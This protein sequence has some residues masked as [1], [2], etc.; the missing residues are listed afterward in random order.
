MKLIVKHFNE[1]ELSELY[2]ILKARQEVFVVEQN[3]AYVDADG[4][5]KD[6][7][8]VFYEENGKILACLRVL[9]RGVSFPEVSF[10]R[11]ITTKR[12]CG[13]G[14]KIIEAGVSVAKE[15]YR[16]DCIKISAQL[17]AKGFY[18]KQGFVQISDVYYEDGIEHVCMEMKLI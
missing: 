3:C 7:Y 17:Q 13:L 11:I 1:L 6:A 18:E 10:G 5:D 4:K 9:D 8:H 15:K 12:S 2:E 14:S 16:A